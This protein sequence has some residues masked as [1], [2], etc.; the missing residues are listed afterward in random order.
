MGSSYNSFYD[1]NF[2]TV[3]NKLYSEEIKVIEQEIEIEKDKMNQAKAGKP[4]TPTLKA[5]LLPFREK[6]SQLTEEKKKLLTTFI[7]EYESIRTAIIFSALLSEEKQNPLAVY[8]EYIKG[9]ILPRVC[10][11]LRKPID[12]AVDDNCMKDEFKILTELA[13]D[14]INN[15]FADI[16]SENKNTPNFVFYYN[17]LINIFILHIKKL[18]YTM[19]IIYDRVIINKEADIHFV[20]LFCQGDYTTL[21]YKQGTAKDHEYLSQFIKGDMG[22]YILS[23]VA[24]KD[25]LDNITKTPNAIELSYDIANTALPMFT[26]L[27]DL[28]TFMDI[29]GHKIQRICILSCLNYNKYNYTYKNNNKPCKVDSKNFIE[30]VDKIYINPIIPLFTST[31]E[32]FIYGGDAHDILKNRFEDVFKHI[33]DI[34]V[35]GGQL[36]IY[37]R[38][39]K[40]DTLNGGS[41]KYKTKTNKQKKNI[42]C[43]TKKCNTRNTRN[44]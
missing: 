18:I 14:T 11:L 3:V 27:E 41:S 30:Y 1:F 10:K 7:S 2:D 8:I 20:L 19:C 4:Y 23:H 6:I 32:L 13:P 29:I 17:D 9:E 39:V 38:Y 42:N 15:L 33:C 43:K 37:K 26:S 25:Q 40:H 44:H 36:A 31:G 28:S 21:L 16:I 24:C 34:I 35:G 12:A 22:K 5:A